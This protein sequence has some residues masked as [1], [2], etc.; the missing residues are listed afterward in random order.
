MWSKIRLSWTLAAVCLLV[1]ALANP[2]GAA[3][4]SKKP[5]YDN[6][7]LY[8]TPI[9]VGPHFHFSQ[10]GDIVYQTAVWSTS[11][12]RWVHSLYLYQHH[13]GSTTL[14]PSGNWIKSDLQINDKGQVVWG[15]HE[16][17]SGRDRIYLYNDGVTAPISG[18]AY[19]SSQP[20]LNNRGQVAY[21]AYSG[22][23]TEIYFFDGYVSGP[24]AGGNSSNISPVINDNGQVAWL[25]YNTGDEEAHVYFF[26]GSASQRVSGTGNAVKQ[27]I[28]HDGWVIWEIGA[29]ET[30]I[31]HYA[32]YLYKGGDPIANTE[33][34]A[35]NIYY[36]SPDPKFGASGQV[37]WLGKE[38]GSGNIYLKQYLNGVT[39]PVTPTVCASF[40]VNHQG[41]IAY[42]A[43]SIIYL[44]SKGASTRISPSDPFSPIYINP[45]INNNGQIVY[46]RP[47]F[48]SDGDYNSHQEVYVYNRGITKLDDR[49]T[50][51]YDRDLQLIDNGQVAWFERVTAHITTPDEARIW[52]ARPL[53]TVT[54]AITLLLLD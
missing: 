47:V 48:P 32:L 10:N 24:L 9:S 3:L 41:Q 29:G 18:T 13:T 49:H 38:A 33:V 30:Y 23:D 53:S 51:G 50:Y 5:I 39:S 17:A 35:T 52:L 22:T 16:V 15:E 4:Y 42:S 12:G 25:G 43:G 34:L 20:K 37:V 7:N 8:P 11:L 14:I 45:I 21:M 31:D 40:D 2:A 54:P 44:Y 36:L 19:T 26:D 27:Q 46:F 6:T 1:I 28:N